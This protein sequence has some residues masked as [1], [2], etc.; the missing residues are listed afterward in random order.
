MS[1]QH[2]APP[3]RSFDRLCHAP[4]LGAVVG[5][6]SPSLV[7]RRVKD[8]FENN[9][10]LDDLEK[11]AVLDIF[12]RRGSIPQIVFAFE[13][14][15][16]NLETQRKLAMRLLDLVSFDYAFVSSPIGSYSSFTGTFSLQFD[17]STRELSSAFLT[18]VG[19]VID[20]LTMD[21]QIKRLL[22][23][24]IQ[25]PSNYSLRAGLYEK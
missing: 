13:T 1:L 17:P 24:A 5:L 23:D 19:C 18:R 6:I 3:V 7:F 11:T 14:L 21:S 8:R 9:F 15:S 12:A 4:F 20:S 10:P 2:A 25:D 16:P 22:A